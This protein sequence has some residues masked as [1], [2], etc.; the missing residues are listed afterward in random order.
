M[1]TSRRNEGKPIVVTSTGQSTT[2]QQPHAE[3]TTIG[4]RNR[5][6]EQAEKLSPG[7]DDLVTPADFYNVM[8]EFRGDAI[9]NEFKRRW[10]LSIHEAMAQAK[11][12]SDCQMV[13]MFCSST[14]EV[15]QNVIIRWIELCKTYDEI[16]AVYAQ[17]MHTQHMFRNSC[18][19]DILL[20]KLIELSRTVA[21]ARATVRLVE[22]RH[23][24]SITD[25]AY[26][27]LRQ[28]CIREQQKREKKKT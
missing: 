23:G 22:E 20:I 12:A 1:P 25:T 10:T 27:N 7:L 11:E 15:R 18:F 24:T 13:F 6:M 16:L 28:A 21:E 2:P 3:E 4:H 5:I 26:E 17:T 14:M 9:R 8:T 19:T